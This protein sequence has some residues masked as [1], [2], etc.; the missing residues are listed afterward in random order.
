M[1]HHCPWIG[2]CV[3]Y[4]NMKPFFL[5]TFYQACSGIVFFVTL[6][7]R[8][9]EAP[10]D[11]P[12]LSFWGNVCFWVTAVIDMPVCFALLGLAPSIFV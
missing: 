11:L 5:F 4:H 1:D 3:G 12:D 8:V 10:D 6:M 2:N 9:F 7:L